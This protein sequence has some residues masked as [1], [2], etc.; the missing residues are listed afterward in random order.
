MGNGERM[1]GIDYRIGQGGEML[2][3]DDGGRSRARWG[4]G[5]GARAKVPQSATL[6]VIKLGGVG[7]IIHLRR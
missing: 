7:D 2:W 6:G 3:D 5:V 1:R 4:S